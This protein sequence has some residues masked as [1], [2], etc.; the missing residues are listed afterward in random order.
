[1]C[2]CKFY[3]CTLTVWSQPPVSVSSSHCYHVVIITSSMVHSD[4]WLTDWLTKL[5]EHHI[6]DTYTNDD[7]MHRWRRPKYL[8]KPPRRQ[9]QQ[10]PSEEKNKLLSCWGLSI[11]SDKPPQASQPVDWSFSYQPASHHWKRSPLA[12]LELDISVIFSMGL[13]RGPTPSR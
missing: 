1:M 13:E 7:I 10:R 12:Q 6:D 8:G 3:I 5:T 9:K 2:V 4:C 11:G